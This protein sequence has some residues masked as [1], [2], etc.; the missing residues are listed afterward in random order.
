MLDLIDADAAS[1]RHALAAIEASF[2]LGVASSVLGRGVV[3]QQD[4]EDAL[5]RVGVELK[6][7]EG[8]Q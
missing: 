5:R 8:I 1:A 4:I 6:P 2:V 7:D 3:A